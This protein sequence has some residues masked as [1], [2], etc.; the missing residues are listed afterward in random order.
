M[1]ICDPE[2][3]GWP[4]FTENVPT[5]TDAARTTTARNRPVTA[6]PTSGTPE[7]Q[8]RQSQH[9]NDAGRGHRPDAERRHLEITQDAG[10]QAQ[11]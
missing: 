8:S 3:R 4:A 7:R 10:G 5:T 9:G 11:D 2:A 1:T 6:A